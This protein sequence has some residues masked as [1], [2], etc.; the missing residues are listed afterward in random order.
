MPTILIDEDAQRILKEW[1][2]NLEA[3]GIKA[4]YSAAIREMDREIDLTRT[5]WKVSE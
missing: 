1:K 5:V 3:K 4:T 2:G